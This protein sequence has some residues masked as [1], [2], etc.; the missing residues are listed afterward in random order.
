MIAREPQRHSQVIMRGGKLGIDSQGLA[1]AIH[2]FFSSMEDHQ[3]E[4]Y[5]V[6]ESRRGFGALLHLIEPCDCSCG[7]TLG[8]QSVN[9]GAPDR[10]CDATRLSYA[11][12]RNE[13]QRKRETQTREASTPF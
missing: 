12:C 4:S 1:E 3:Q 13:Q 9:F 7:V 10:S 11:G 8:F 5:L 2:G 6:F